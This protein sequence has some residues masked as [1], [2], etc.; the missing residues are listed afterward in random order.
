MAVA[1]DDAGGQVRAVDH[2]GALHFAPRAD[3]GDLALR[4]LDLPVLEDAL[5]PTGPDLLRAHDEGVRLLRQRRK[6]VGSERVAVGLWNVGG[7]GLLGGTGLRRRRSF[8]RGLQRALRHGLTPDRALA[9]LTTNPAR[10]L[11]FADRM[12]TIEKGKLANL[13]VTDRPLFQ[14]DRKVRAL[15]ID[16]KH[17]EVE[18]PKGNGLAG[19]WALDQPSV[20]LTIDRKHKITVRV[21]VR[22]HRVSLSF[23]HGGVL[24][25]LSGVLEGDR[26]LGHGVTAAGERFTW[27]AT[28]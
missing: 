13:V 20:T 21:D 3:V 16:G 15:W 25:T 24:V 18:P 5:R 8:P 2:V 23:D 12:G 6:R 11:G 9:M 17:Y 26:M 10:I 1:I 27:T 22:G 7:Y 14:R 28:R 19:E 4:D